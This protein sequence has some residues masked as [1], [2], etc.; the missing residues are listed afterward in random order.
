MTK[1]DLLRRAV[2]VH[3][4]LAIAVLAQGAEPGT[5]ANTKAGVQAW[6]DATQAPEVRAGQVLKAMSFEQKVALVS[7]VDPA[8]Y[9]P[10]APLGIQP[11]TRVDASAGLRGD[12]GVTAFPV[13]LMLGATFDA[14]LARRYG[15]A[16]AVEARGKGWNVILGPTVDVA[17]DGLSGRLTESFGEDPLVNAV[18]GSEVASG[19]QGEGVIAM[20]KHYTVYHTERERL[21]MNVEVGP[22]ALREVYDL[23]FHYLIEKARIGSLMGSYPKVNGTFMLE[24]AALLA[25]IK[26][27]GF[28]GYMATDFMG[29]ADG[30]A[31]FNAG[32]DSWSLQPFLRKAEGFRDGRIPASR[33]DDAARRMLW[34]LFS[35]GT[36]DRPV[37]GTPAA[38]VTNPEHQ[39]LAVQV[40]ESGTVLLKNEGNVLPLRRTGQIAVIGPAGKETVTGVMWSTFVDPGQFTT[41][42]EAIAARAGTGAKVVHAQGSLGD[43]VLPSMSADGGIFAPPVGLVAP[44]GKPGWQVRY[45][46]SEDFSGAALA[47]DIVKEIDIKGRPSMAMP[48]KWSA[49]WVTDYTPDRDGAVR[50]ATSLSGTVKVKVDGKA[51]VDGARSTAE[52]FPGSG[53]NTYPLHGVVQLEKG[54]K[55]RIEVEYSSRGAF[56][57]PR[58]QLGWQGASMIPDAVALAKKSDAAVVFVNQVTGEEMDRDN[59]ALPAD[60]DAL[61]EAVA[62]ANPNTVVVLNTGGAVKMPW[63]PRVKGVVQMWYP[64]AAS[65]TAIAN[66]LFGDAEPG[67]RL[68]VSFPADESQGP[69]PYQGGGTVRYDEGVF[70]G[71]R[72]LHKHGQKPLFPFGYGLSYSSFGLDGLEVRAEKG[73]KGGLADVAATV[74]VRVKNTGARAG[75]TVVQVYNGALPAPVD[76]PAVKLVGF[77]RVQLPAGGEQVVTIPVERRLLSY[78]DEKGGKWVTPAGKVSLGVGFNAAEIVQRQEAVLSR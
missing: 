77:V 26:R 73:G 68:P 5:E 19:M 18:M 21:T 28:H 30:I 25:Q 49:R 23:P 69:R 50:L 72:Y 60:Q 11:L 59:Y 7:G 74:S 58:I 52:G 42:V 41:P 29:G 57:G 20:A 55:V 2:A 76:T 36:F 45:F 56:T 15:R 22:R 37:T 3:V 39:A 51:V 47:Q 48:A 34:A 54:R 8:D 65:G 63:L 35:T 9:A 12:K 70:T 67:G 33:L 1:N 46:G 13:P 6:R 40:A 78:W 38:V 71:Y 14:A 64:G 24:N 66:V 61:V 16:I 53:P 62:A 31:Q 75:S 32:I 10:L 44:D 43:A 4:G 17:R 27:H